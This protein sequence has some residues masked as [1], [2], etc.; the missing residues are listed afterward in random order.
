MGSKVRELH[1]VLVPGRAEAGLVGEVQGCQCGV[2]RWDRGGGIQQ[3]ELGAFKQDLEAGAGGEEVLVVTEN[4]VFEGGRGVPACC[5]SASV[6]A[7]WDA[8]GMPAVYR[9][10]KRCHRTLTG[11]STLTSRKNGRRSNASTT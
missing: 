8:V 6:S 7:E 4:E 3:L 2:E 10:L 1:E 9:S 11:A 5:A